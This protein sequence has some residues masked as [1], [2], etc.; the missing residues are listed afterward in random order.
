MGC[1][2]QVIQRVALQ[3]SDEQRAKFMADVSR[4]DPSMLLWID[5]SGCD[6]RNCMRKRG[7]S[8]RG[9]TPKDHRLMVR[10]T[11][12]SAIPVMSLDGIHNVYLAEGNMNGEKFA[13]FVRSC[14]LPVL[15]PFNY[16][17]PHSVVIL[18]NAS[19]HH[20]EG[21]SHNW[22]ASRCSIT[23]FAPLFTR[24][25]SPG[26]GFQQGEGHHENVWWSLSN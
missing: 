25:K 1:T 20:V 5:K 19:I 18:D 6:R 3:R 11:C 21:I 13:T 17:N 14:L 23:F 10:G 15:Q 16:T 24:P 22:G 9:M 2:R 8:L 26:G 12:Y 4:Y 7:Y